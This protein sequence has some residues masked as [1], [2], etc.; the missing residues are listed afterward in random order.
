MSPVRVPATR[1]APRKKRSFLDSTHPTYRDQYQ[2]W[3]RNERR[4]LGGD[5]ILEE[6]I[7]FDW[8]HDRGPESHYNLRKENAV[9]LN[10]PDRFASLMVGHMMR[11]APEAGGTLSFGTLGDVRRLRDIDEP[12]PAELFY[13]NT[14]GL[15]SDGSQWNS[16]WTHVIKGAISTGH[17]WILAEGPPQQPGNRGREIAGLR[18]VLTDFSP[19][20]VR[21]WH[22]E[23]G[24][25]VMAL[26]D[27]YTRTLRLNDQGE[28]EGNEGELETLLLTA[29]G[30]VGFGQEFRNGGWYVF[31]P[32]GELKRFGFYEETEGE[33]PMVALYYERLKAGS[34]TSAISRS[35]ITEMGN[36]AVGYMNLASGADFD[37][38]DS[39]TSALALLGADDVGFNV[40]VAKRNEG[41]RYAPLPANQ[42]TGEIPKIQDVSTGAIT[43]DVFD[44]RLKAKRQEAVELMLN[45]IES[46]PYASGE[47]KRVS[48]MD[49]KAPRLAV[50]ASE[51]ETAQNS[52]IHFVELM[53]GRGRPQPSGAVEWPREFDLLDVAHTAKD[54][55]EIE[56]LAQLR[57]PTAAR[58]VMVAVTQRMGIVGDTEE[59]TTVEREYEESAKER[60]EQKV[61]P[62]RTTNDEGEPADLR[63]SLENA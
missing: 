53:W 1:G 10:F 45:E 30:F 19:L 48:F 51:L 2:L 13:Y 40:F 7:P 26:I 43:A 61:P 15:G 24:K 34:Q 46:A 5:E 58:K 44:K 57:S 33:I 42:D 56:N 27:R 11:Q 50:L 17:R 62:Q 41:N 6:L 25:L 63:S 52:I 35:G 37:A 21:N 20:Q 22:Y 28:L 16:Y 18:P 49:A 36:A 14:D 4:M 23:N 59:R 55:F 8:E 39:A 29:D 3:R 9:Y 47:S 31:D 12:S 38:W 54:F 32:E 60:E